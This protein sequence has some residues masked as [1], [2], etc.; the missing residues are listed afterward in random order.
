VDFSRRFLYVDNVRGVRDLGGIPTKFGGYIAYDKIIRGSELNGPANDSNSIMASSTALSILRSM[1]ITLDMD[2]RTDEEAEFI[3]E[4]PLG[5]PTKYER[6]SF[7]TFQNINT[8]TEEEKSKIKTAFEKV[9]NEVIDGGKV[10]IHCVWGY[11]RCGFLCT[12]IEGIL[13][14]T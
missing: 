4:S 10:Y 7:I 14:A 3:T 9:A 6:I 12:L 5:T 13:G 2:L 1:N 11:H 8:L